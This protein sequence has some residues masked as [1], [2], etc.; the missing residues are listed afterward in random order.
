L[1]NIARKISLR[2]WPRPVLLRGLSTFNSPAAK[3]IG[4]QH[5]AELGVNPG[6]SPLIS[7]IC[8]AYVPIKCASGASETQVEVLAWQ[9]ASKLD[10]PLICQTS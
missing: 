6:S 5:S 4:A 8:L 1:L 7:Q 10:G 2:G 9:A 3:R